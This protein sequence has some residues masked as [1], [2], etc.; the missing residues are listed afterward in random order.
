MFGGASSDDSAGWL[1]S[2][3][4]APSSSP[5]E[6]LLSGGLGSLSVPP[7]LSRSVRVLVFGLGVE[8]V[9]GFV[10]GLA[11]SC[12]VPSP[13]PSLV[14]LFLMLLFG[15]VDTAVGCCIVPSPFLPT[16]IFFVPLLLP[17]VVVAW[18]SIFLGG[19]SSRRSSR[20]RS[21]G[22]RLEW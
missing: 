8:L 15:G 16:P 17:L 13:F 21:S 6:L 14:L 2:A 19:R 9:V 18:G 1:V 5:A 10:G 12:F 11:V 4:F 22:V 7:T 20:G 3:C